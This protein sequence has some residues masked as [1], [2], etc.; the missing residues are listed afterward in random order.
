MK[1]S[2]D[3]EKAVAENPATEKV[4]VN[5]AFLKALQAQHAEDQERVAELEDALEKTKHE[6]MVLIEKAATI[7]WNVYMDTCKKNGVSPASYEHWCSAREIRE[8]KD[9]L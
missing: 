5:Y 4:S 9:E 2:K 8:L 6:K 1:D 7:A 3:F